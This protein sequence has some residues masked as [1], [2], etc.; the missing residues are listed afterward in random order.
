MVPGL[1]EFFLFGIAGG[2]FQ[3]QIGKSAKSAM[4]SRLGLAAIKTMYTKRK[5][6]GVTFTFEF[7]DEF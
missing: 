7:D 4:G 2:I 1:I 5:D 6:A 3:R